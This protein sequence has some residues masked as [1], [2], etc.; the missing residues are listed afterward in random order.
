MYLLIWIILFT[1]IGS[2]AS[3][4]GGVLLLYWKQKQ[5][6]KFGHLLVS[7]AAGTMLA[8]AFFDLI[9]EA[10]EL[11]GVADMTFYVFIGVIFF[12]V[13]EKF[14]HWRHCHEKRCLEHN[15][16]NTEEQRFNKLI[17]IGDAV[18]NF[19]DG[20]II[21][22]AFIINIPLGI[23]TAIAVF[24]HEVPQEIGNFAILLYGGM[25]RKKIIVI[26]LITAA[27]ALAGAVATFFL[28]P[29][30][31]PYLPILISFAAGGFLYIALG[32][33]IPETHKTQCRKHI[34]YH[35]ILLFVGIFLMYA[36][37]HLIGHGHVH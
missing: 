22:A 7:F 36:A 5:T 9:P 20:I 29:M 11:M 14:L 12:F 28:A 15:I 4:F 34:A 27:L 26:N 35:T 24:M 25:K 30:I 2:I 16:T 1:C 8:A 31:E 21:A 37:I 23:V 13:L 32:D 6:G 3:L 10:G 19:I 18:H 33:L 17:I